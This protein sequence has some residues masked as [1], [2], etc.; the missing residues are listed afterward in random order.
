MS[1]AGVPTIDATDQVE[2]V[3]VTAIRPSRQIGTMIA[4]CTI[5]EDGYDE[6]TIT[7]HPVEQGAAITDHAF[8][9]PP[10]I[11]IFAKWSN[12]SIQAGGDASYCATQYQDLLTLQKDRIPFDV[13]TPQRSYTDMLIRS[14]AKHTDEK[15]ENALE[16]TIRCRNII[17]VQTQTTKVPKNDVQKMPQKTGAVQNGGTRN[18]APASNFNGGR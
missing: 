12:S 10:G 17:I 9:N 3:T 14:I 13:V 6:L 18:T 4:D 16:C 11:T 7:E 1:N 2:S 15:T 8:I 5:S